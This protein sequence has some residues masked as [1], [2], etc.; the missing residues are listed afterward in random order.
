[1]SPKERFNFM[2]EP[3][4]LAALRAIEAK[5]GASLGGQIRRAIQ[6]Y[7]DTQTVLTKSEV[8]RIQTEA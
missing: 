2:I 8:R 5:T 1:M 3:G 7:L 4:Q 6:A